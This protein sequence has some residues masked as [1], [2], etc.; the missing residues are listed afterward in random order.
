MADY[1]LKAALHKLNA[2]P[3]NFALIEGKHSDMVLVTPNPAPGKLISDTAEE[4]GDGK[5]VAKGIC[6]WENG[7]L[8][9]ATRKPPMPSW[10]SALKKIFEEHKCT[11]FLPVKLRQMDGNESK[12]PETEDEDNS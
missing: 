10:K 3:F 8:V 2:K 12:V 4:C 9:F 7:K 5:R 1:N 11:L 6:L